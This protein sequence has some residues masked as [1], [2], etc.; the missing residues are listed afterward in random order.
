M[1][2]VSASVRQ[3]WLETSCMYWGMMSACSTTATQLAQ[4]ARAERRWAPE[5]EGFAEQKRAQL[6]HLGR[7]MLVDLLAVRVSLGEREG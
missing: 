7:S 1:L 2:A 5:L 4:L 6:L 3:H